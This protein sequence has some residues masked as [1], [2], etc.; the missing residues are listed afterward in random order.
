MRESVL[1]IGCGAIGL[2]VT[3]RLG[4]DP[5]VHIEGRHR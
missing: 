4:G 3:R 1:L 5:Q 2:E